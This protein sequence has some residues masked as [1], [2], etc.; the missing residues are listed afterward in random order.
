MEG[1]GAF[2]ILEVHY[3]ISIHSL[4]MEGDGLSSSVLFDV[5]AFQSTPSAWRETKLNREEIIDEPISIHSLR[6]EG[7]TV[8]VT[9]AAPEP[10]FQSTPS[11]WRETRNY[12]GGICG[13]NYIISIHSLRME[14]DSY[15]SVRFHISSKISIHSLRMEGDSVEVSQPPRLTYFNP[16]P[17]HGGRL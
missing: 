7:D 5:L 9:P 11:A 10:S 16:L 4:R 6:M 17:P 1:D 3:Y 13:S 2:R 14:G 15:F 8:A 12:I